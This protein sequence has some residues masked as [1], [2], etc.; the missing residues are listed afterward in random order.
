MFKA[1]SYNLA[2]IKPEI[3]PSFHKLFLQQFSSLN[4]NHFLSFSKKP[5]ADVS[6]FGFLF[7]DEILILTR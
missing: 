3:S 5:N 6:T 2:A 4:N 7:F 1:D